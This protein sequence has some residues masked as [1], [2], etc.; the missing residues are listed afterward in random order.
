[1]KEVEMRAL[2]S[3]YVQGVGFRFTTLTH[4]KCLHLKGKVR[5]LPDGK[6]EIFAQGAPD[7]LE[8]LLKLLETDSGAARV[9]HIEKRL[10]AIETIYTDFIIEK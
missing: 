3:G 8:K 1:M 5:N 10:Y 4:A 2:V 6:V 7:T 9:Q